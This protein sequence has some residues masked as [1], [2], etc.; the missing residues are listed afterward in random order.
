MSSKTF[1][2]GML[3][4]SIALVLA[5]GATPFAMAAE[6]AKAANQ[7]TEVIEVRGIRG[8]LKANINA[9]RFS[10]AVVDV[11]N[12]E[13]IGKFPDGDVGEALGRI[14]GVAVN[15]QFGQ[16]QQVSIRGVSNQLTSTLLN[17]HSVSTTT[18]YD[19]QAM[20]RSFNYTLMPPEMVGGIEIYKSSQADLQ[21]GGIGGT[22]IVKTRKPLDLDANTIFASIKG[23]YG[24]VS[25]ETD[26]QV[27]G[28]Y[29]W[30]N[31]EEDFGI[32]ASGSFTETNYQRTAV[33]NILGW[34]G[35]VA[36]T[37]FKQQRE[38]TAINLAAQ[39]RPTEELEFGVSYMELDFQADNI[40]TSMFLF[41]EGQAGAIWTP[42]EDNGKP[43][44]QATNAAGA[45]VKS[46]VA[47]NQG[48]SWGQTWV[49]DAEMNSKTFDFDMT[50][51]GEGY[52]FDAL[53]GT[54]EAEGGTALTAAQRNG[55]GQQADFAGTYDATG[56]EYII[57]IAKKSYTR[58]DFVGDLDIPGWS[59]KS[60]PNTDEETY[61][62]AN[63]QFDVD[64]GA[65]VA[66][67]TGFSWSNHEVTDKT[68]NANM[69]DA[70]DILPGTV[71]SLYHSSQLNAAQGFS[72]PE[73]NYNAMIAR[74]Y[75]SFDGFTLDKSSYATLE[76]DNLA[77]YVMAD[78][79]A[80][81]IRGNF[82]LRYIS[83]DIESDYYNISLDADGNAT[84]ADTLST[85]KADYD[86]F[87][88]SINIAFDLSDELILRTSAAQVISRPNYQEVFAKR[89]QSGFAD[90]IQGN[91]RLNTG[92]VGLSP[93]KATQADFSLEWYYS[94]DGM[95]SVTYFIKDI[96]TFI[97]T[98]EILNQSIGIV[99]PVFG[100]DDWTLST[101]KNAPGGK[102]NGLEFQWQDA[103]DNGFGYSINYTYVDSD[104]NAENYPDMVAQFSD[105]SENTVNLVG[106]YENDDF[107]A[108]LA[109]NWRSEYMIRELPGF[110]GNRMHDDFGT[111]DF[112][113][114]YNVSENITLSFE[115]VNI[116]EEDSIQYGAAPAGAEGV[117][118]E[119]KENYPT[120]F[121]GG[122][123]RYK[124]GVTLRF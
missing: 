78:F 96:E 43:A 39:Y 37:V 55:L 99:D 27:S 107:S 123:A 91:E 33:E 56:S 6:E 85:D 49:R 83:T 67:K 118:T 79:E 3:A 42:Y 97:T 61:L 28:M 2:K 30:K 41:S 18:W 9:K 22:I 77:L 80:D 50:Y 8:S 100:T 19:Q 54:T 74:A 47:A 93:F 35:S 86:D 101:K 66:I 11:V 7:E 94:D 105:S 81:G 71:S 103:F 4:S 64:Y 1:K 84:Y 112:S 90:D 15:R 72:L 108:R 23:D 31:D 62:Q 14:A 34:G 44:C 40:N 45:C 106:Y 52:T 21:E 48:A 116:L 17:G 111:L 24:T 20:D 75:S 102:I 121:F 120:W 76:E 87:L 122:E 58:D 98:G 32:L 124:V 36:P 68:L 69:K 109:Y 46:T 113:A 95:A 70:A 89:S 38:R 110:Y 12:A 117:I 16:G 10:N 29:S 25:E 65:I 26:P 114:S 53:L 104:E 63:L 5:G 115:G 88:P 119:F 13:D 73:A 60:Q 57:D 51:E 59:V 82:G 92:D